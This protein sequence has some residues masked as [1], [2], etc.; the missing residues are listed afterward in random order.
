MRWQPGQAVRLLA[1]RDELVGRAFDDPGTWWPSSP[2]VV[3]GRDRQAGGTW[4]AT[5]VVTGTTAL[6]LNRPQRQVAA[7]GAPSRGVLPLLAV[8][9]GAAWPSAVAL[10]GMASFL[11]VLAG[12]DELTTWEFD[13]T[14]LTSRSLGPGTH[15]V[16]SGGTEDRRAQ[17]HLA[18]LTGT[19][20]WLALV[21]AQVAS[22]DPSSLLVR[23]EVGDRVF[24][25]VFGQLL[26]ASPGRLVVESSRTPG[27]ASSWTTRTWPAQPGPGPS[28]RVG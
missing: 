8:G 11:L 1:L 9:A 28:S 25:T 20:D 4:C 19:D 14:S 27:D 21:T 24:A 22:A 2:V 5:S 18:A 17:R 12:P 13:G 15:M 16:T 3:G 26:E 6:V 23:H 10:D 7:P